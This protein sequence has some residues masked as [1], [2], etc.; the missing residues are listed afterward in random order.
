MSVNSNFCSCYEQST[1]VLSGGSE[2]AIEAC[3][4]WPSLK[5][6]AGLFCWRNSVSV[7][8]GLSSYPVHIPLGKPCQSPAYRYRPGSYIW[9]TQ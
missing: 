1:Q 2:L 4:L 9:E 6:V 7:F 8:L 3:H 5:S